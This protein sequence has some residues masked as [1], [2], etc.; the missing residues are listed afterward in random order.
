MEKLTE[1]QRLKKR[2]VEIENKQAFCKHEWGEVEY[3]PYQEEGTRREWVYQGSDSHYDY[4]GTGVFYK[5]DRWK[6]VCKKCEKVE[7]A[8]EYE[9]E[10]VEVVKEKKLKFR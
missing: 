2:I 7:Y 1:L 4:V 8:Y 6:R 10:V 5:K 3:D 9:E